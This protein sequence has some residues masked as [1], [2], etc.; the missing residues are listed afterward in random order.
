V[1]SMSLNLTRIPVKLLFALIAIGAAWGQ[2]DVLSLEGGVTNAQ[3]EIVLGLYFRDV[4]GTL[5][6]TGVSAFGYFSLNFKATYDAD[7]V[8]SIS[9]VRAGLSASVTP[10]VFFAGSSEPSTAWAYL[11]DQHRHG[12]CQRQR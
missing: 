5:I 8:D 1:L 7:L 10:A 9:F 12:Q 3:Q 11:P 4:P 6:D 2:N